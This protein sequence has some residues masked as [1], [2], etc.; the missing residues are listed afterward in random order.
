MRRGPGRDVGV[1]EGEELGLRPL[2]V[3]LRGERDVLLQPKG[4]GPI[5]RGGGRGGASN[6]GI[7]FEVNFFIS[8]KGPLR[9]LCAPFKGCQFFH[10]FWKPPDGP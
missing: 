5:Q 10:S 4:G 3:E 9:N 6:S 8:M 1:G 7:F 2:V